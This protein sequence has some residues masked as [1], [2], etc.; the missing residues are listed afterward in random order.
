MDVML[1]TPESAG[2]T[3]TS[4][5]GKVAVVTGAN[6]GIG[7]ATALYL[8]DLGATVLMGCRSAGKCDK[9]AAEINSKTGHPRFV[10]MIYL[11]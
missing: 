11:P 8:V 5:S 2:F 1:W 6:S 3:D 7:Y 9:A 4:L 10:A